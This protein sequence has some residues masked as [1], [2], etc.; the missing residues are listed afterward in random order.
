MGLCCPP[1][2][3]EFPIY[4]RSDNLQTTALLSSKRTKQ[5]SSS[6]GVLWKAKAFL[7]K[8]VERRLHPV[9]YDPVNLV[10][11]PW[12]D[13]LGKQVSTTEKGPAFS[14]LY[15]IPAPRGL[16]KRCFMA[17]AFFANHYPQ[18]QSAHDVLPKSPVIPRRSPVSVT[19]PISRALGNQVSHFQNLPSLPPE[20]VP[21]IKGISRRLINE[22]RKYVNYR[23]V[24]TFATNKL[25]PGA[26]VSTCGENEER[27][28][29]VKHVNLLRFHSYV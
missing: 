27:R 23:G 11:G 28:C 9:S 10:S 6:S 3:E 15:L 19:R 7:P 1:D 14:L 4:E 18:Q 13:L 8:F 2:K 5:N 21:F 22:L 26:H 17:L 16:H 25:I 29:L 12:V 24:S 20:L